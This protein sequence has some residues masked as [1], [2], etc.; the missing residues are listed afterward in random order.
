VLAINYLTRERSEGAIVDP[1]GEALTRLGVDRHA[2]YLIRPD[3]HVAF[4]SGG[5]DLHGPAAYLAH[6]FTPSVAEG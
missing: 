2:T 4:R 6:W 1:T 3:G 5:T